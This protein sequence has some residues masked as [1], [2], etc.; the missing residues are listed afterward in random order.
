[1]RLAEFL[2]WEERQPERYE[3]VRGEVR[4]VAGENEEH[5]RIANNLRDALGRHLRGT[6]CSR[7]GPRLRVATPRDDVLYPEAFVRCGPADGTAM[8]RD[9]PLAVFE[10]LSERSAEY[11]LTVKRRMYQA[12]SSVRAIACV[13]Q[14]AQRLYVFERRG[15]GAWLY[16]EVE[17][18][19]A[20]L[21]VEAARVR[22]A[23][24]ELYE[25]TDL[26]RGRRP[27]E[28]APG[29]S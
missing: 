3:L 27:P 4:R 17:G 23:L 25:G 28:P 29:P 14:S 2:A 18:P 10:V 9:D 12:I 5:D 1:V 22:L 15:Y 16:R 6:N 26:R 20:V 7:H 13:S 24:A 21:E 19:G 8:V 11:D